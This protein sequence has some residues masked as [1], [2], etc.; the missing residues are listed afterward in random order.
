MVPKLPPGIAVLGKNSEQ[1]NYTVCKKTFI[2]NNTA[3]GK[4]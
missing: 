2:G 3:S 4:M 1:T